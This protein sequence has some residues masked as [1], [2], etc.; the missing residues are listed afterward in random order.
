M[1]FVCADPFLQL[2]RS[3]SHAVVSQNVIPWVVQGVY[4]ACPALPA[5]LI[6]N[7]PNVLLL[8]L[9]LYFLQAG[10]DFS[11]KEAKRQGMKKGSHF[12]DYLLFLDAD[13]VRPTTQPPLHHLP[14]TP[15]PGHEP[16]LK[17]KIQRTCLYRTTSECTLQGVCLAS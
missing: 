11:L 6:N 3:S 1:L 15:L 10:I 5:G 9:L 16:Y 14:L 12:C 17:F 8:L 13:Q 4:N 2:Q 7:G